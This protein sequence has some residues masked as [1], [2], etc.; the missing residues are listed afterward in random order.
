MGVDTGHQTLLHNGSGHR[1][2]DT[3]AQQ[4]WTQEDTR[5]SCTTGENTAQYWTPRIAYLV[6]TVANNKEET[7]F[8]TGCVVRT[9]PE[10]VF[11]PHT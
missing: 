4:E 7:V 11:R 3:P 2:P 5:H 8:Q 6:N 10:V 9:V 1:T